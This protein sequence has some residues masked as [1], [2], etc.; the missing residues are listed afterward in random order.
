MKKI[1]Y[2]L[3]FFTMLSFSN[4]YTAPLENYAVVDLERVLQTSKAYESFQK[5]AN[6][7]KQALDAE[8]NKETESL[9]TI[10]AD[11]AQ[12]RNNYSPVEFEK[13]RKDLETKVAN[14]REK[15]QKKQQAFD[16]NAGEVLRSVQEQLQKIM[17]KLVKDEKY[18]IIFLAAGLAYYDKSKDISDIVLDKLNKAVPSVTLKKI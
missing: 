17:A 14:F 8:F 3:L 2:T 9:K 11:L 16:A 18:E 1:L 6:T 5:Q 13:K 12:N 10:E 4:G 7:Q 15:V